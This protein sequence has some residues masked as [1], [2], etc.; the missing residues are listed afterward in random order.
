MRPWKLLLD[1]SIR[2]DEWSNTQN[3]NTELVVQ[4]SSF[5]I[6]NSSFVPSSTNHL[7]YPAIPYLATAVRQILTAQ[8]YK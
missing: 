6:R 1:G 5:N 2:N 3:P 7:P 4:H 8:Q